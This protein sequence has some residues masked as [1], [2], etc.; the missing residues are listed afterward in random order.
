MWL[1]DGSIHDTRFDGPFSSIPAAA[2]VLE[3]NVYVDRLYRDGTGRRCRIKCGG[4]QDT[5]WYY[6]DD[7]TIYGATSE[8]NLDRLRERHPEL[9]IRRAALVSDEFYARVHAQSAADY[10]FG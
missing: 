3:I 7:K 4:G 8:R 1:D 10:D 5:D 2:G 9:H 6:S